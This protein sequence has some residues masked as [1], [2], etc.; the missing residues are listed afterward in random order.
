MNQL[1]E[2]PQN[3][4]YLALSLIGLG[5][6][7]FLNQI[8][9]FVNIGGMMWPFFVI[10]PGVIFL[11]L[12][13]TGDRTKTGFIFPGLIITGT[14]VILLYQSLTGHW[15][16]WAYIWSLYPGMVGLGLRFNGER[17]GKPKE[18]ESGREMMRWSLIAF[19]AFFFLFEVII[20][21]GLTSWMPV[22]L[23]GAGALLLMSQKKSEKAKRKN[24]VLL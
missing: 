24:D 20:F 2:N 6:F 10:V 13:L 14:G 4:N 16:S 8:F 22:V 21:G 23:V 11:Y 17:T 15:E 7:F 18:I 9:N 3:R 19:A 1:F 12:A 5:V